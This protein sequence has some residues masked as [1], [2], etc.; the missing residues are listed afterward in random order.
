MRSTVILYIS[1]SISRHTASTD[2]PDSLSLS[3]S[4]YIYIYIYIAILLYLPSLPAGFQDYVPCPYEAVVDKFWL[5]VQLLHI[6][7]KGSIEEHRSWG[8]FM[9]SCCF[10]GCRF[11]ALFNK[12]RSTLL[13]FSSY[14]FSIRLVSLIV[15]HLWRRIVTNA[16]WKKLRFMVWWVECLLMIREALK[17]VLNTSLLNTQQYKV[18]I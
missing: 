17:M 3:L 13:Q 16:A 4:L 9:Y 18:R 6:C 15:V 12:I 10:V 5:V 11:Q 14:L 2:F 8:K 7:V 1:S